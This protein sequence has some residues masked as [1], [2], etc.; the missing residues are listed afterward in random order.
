ML[1]KAGGRVHWWVTAAL[2]V[3]LPLAFR[4]TGLPMRWDWAGYVVSWAMVAIPSVAM[5][6]ALYTL[7]RRRNPFAARPWPGSIAALVG[8][9][10]Y[11]FL[12]FVLVF[13]F[14]DVIARLRF[15]GSTDLLLD[16]VDALLTFGHPVASFTG[17]VD[18]S[19]LAQDLAMFFYGGMMMQVGATMILV[20]LADGTPRAARFIGAIA[21][22][23]YVGLVCFWL[24]PAT[25]PSFHAPFQSSFGMSELQGRFNDLLRGFE[26]GRLPDRIGT[27][28]FIALPCL[29]VVQPLIVLWFLR[30]WRRIFRW[31]VAFDVALLPSIVLLRQH[32]L[33]DVIAG[34]ALA[35][36]VVALMDRRA[37]PEPAAA[38][39]AAG[40]ALGR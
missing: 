16:R 35:A 28:Y 2:V 19:A 7:E 4:S 3:A 27:D 15:D 34:F 39:S 18:R 6:F 20:W 11:Q 26:Q 29:H 40:E 14:N 5:A 1:A 32:Y 37:A 13:S 36:G 30:G 38:Q 12:M 22:S 21:T 24:L 10:A 33:V 17:F 9:A 23:Y 8:L 31:V 25:S